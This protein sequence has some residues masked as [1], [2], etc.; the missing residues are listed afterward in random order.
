MP[1]LSNLSSRRLCGTLSK[2][3]LKSRK[4]IPSSILYTARVDNEE[5]DL[6]GEI[7]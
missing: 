2:A 7:K 3:L 5:K 1:L 6:Y 4:S